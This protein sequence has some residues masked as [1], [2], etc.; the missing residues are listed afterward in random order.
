MSYRVKNIIIDMPVM[1]ADHSTIQIYRSKVQLNEVVDFPFLTGK[2]TTLIDLKSLHEGGNKISG[3]LIKE[4]LINTAGLFKQVLDI[5]EFGWYYVALPSNKIFNSLIFQPDDLFVDL[6]VRDNVKTANASNQE[7]GLIYSF[8]NPKT[9]T[10]SVSGKVVDDA[11]GVCTK[12]RANLDDIELRDYYLKQC[13]AN[14]AT[15]AA[16]EDKIPELMTQD[17]AADY[18]GISPKTLYNW[19]SSMKIPVTKIGGL[20]KFRRKDLDLWVDNRSGIGAKGGTSRRT[21]RK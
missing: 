21:K 2:I 5:G 6:Y 18:L 12:I 20:N 4:P 15:Q 9:N 17:E 16:F 13:L 8:Y 19:V 11:R 1:G 3:R 10:I 14:Q 7:S